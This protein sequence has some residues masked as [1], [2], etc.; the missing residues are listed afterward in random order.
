MKFDMLIAVVSGAPTFR[1]I[2]TFRTALYLTTGTAFI[3]I[4][5]PWN[6]RFTVAKKGAPERYGLFIFIQWHT[7]RGEG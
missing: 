6:F 4:S 2:L 5:Q 3:R 7:Q 1:G